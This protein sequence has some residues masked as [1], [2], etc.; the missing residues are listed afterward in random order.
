MK[1]SRPWM[2]PIA[3]VLPLFASVLLMIE[4]DAR[5][6]ID[7][8]QKAWL[9]SHE[10]A[11]RLAV[12]AISFL[13]SFYPRE[14]AYAELLAEQ[15]LA[16]G[17][18]EQAL[19]NFKIAQENAALSR[20]GQF[21][22]ARV[23]MALNLPAEVQETLGTLAV[24]A[25]S[26]DEFQVIYNMQR[27]TENYSAALQ[28]AVMWLT[29]FPNDRKARWA[30]AELQVVYDQAAAILNL[31]DLSGGNSLEA[32]KAAELYQ[33]LQDGLAQVNETYTMTLV[34]QKLGAMGEWDLA[35][36]AYQR[37]IRLDPQYAEAYALLGL[38]QTYRGKDGLQNLAIANSL[39]PSSDIVL[40]AWVEYWRAQEL[41]DQALFY[42][43]LLAAEHPQDG[44]WK[45]EIGAIQAQQ[46]DLVSALSSYLDSVALEPENASLWRKF[47]LFCAENGLDWEAYTLPAAST[48]LSLDPQGIETLDM[49][50]WINLI[51]GDLENAERFLQQTLQVDENYPPAMVH[52][53]QVYLRTQRSAEAKKLLEQA[54]SQSTDAKLNLQ[55]QRLLDEDFAKGK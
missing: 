15:Y 29:A 44:A 22:L 7:A 23:E 3:V 14:N 54:L 46:G 2:I 30:A 52:L 50:G 48:A 12:E 19:T 17:D 45:A 24:T 35:E 10:S 41:W 18:Y 42:L 36:L 47:A 11:P 37:A 43:Q 40:T 13:Q 25:E 39:N 6:V 28:T 5:A 21:D 38:A 33:A 34:G 4:P 26:A 9:A 1:R 20:S 16:I 53:A 55:A 8:R 51:H 27:Q 31:A 49:A 32:M